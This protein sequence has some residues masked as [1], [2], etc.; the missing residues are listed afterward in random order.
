METSIGAY[1]NAVL[2]GSSGLGG[3]GEDHV[4]LA[5]VVPGFARFYPLFC[6]PLQVQD[7][8]DHGGPS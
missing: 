8:H 5:V 6:S 1:V 7:R 3:E 2:D 4:D